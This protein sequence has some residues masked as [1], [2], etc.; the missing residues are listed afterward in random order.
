MDTK[1]GLMNGQDE[2]KT[3]ADI[4]VIESAPPQVKISESERRT[5]FW[6]VDLRLLS[7]LTSI[8]LIQYIDRYVFVI[9]ICE[10][11]FNLDCLF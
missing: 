5:L 8:Y 1:T 9:W 7:I 10:R 3:N 2:C 4:S 6:K 11:N